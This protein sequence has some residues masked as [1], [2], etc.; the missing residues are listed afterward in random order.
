MAVL[1]LK[2]ELEKSLQAF[3]DKGESQRFVVACSG[4]YD[5][6]V[7]AHLFVNQF[8]ASKVA[9]QHFNFGLRGEESDAD[10]DYVRK[11]AGEWGTELFVEVAPAREKTGG[12]QE[13][14]R[15]LR[16]AC[17][18]K[19]AAEG[20]VV[21]TGHH[22]QDLT[23][24]VIL[25]MVRG[26]SAGKLAGMQTWDGVVFRPLLSVFPKDIR[27]YA[28][29]NRLKPREDSSNAKVEYSRNFIRHKVLPLLE[30]LAP[31]AL[32]RIADTA[33]D[34]AVVSEFFI[35]EMRNSE[36]VEAEGGFPLS[37]SV[38]E[39]PIEVVTMALGS[40]LTKWKP[41]LRRDFLRGIVRD[42]QSGRKFLARDL[43]KL[44][45]V[46]LED[47][48][49]KV[50]AKSLIPKSERFRQHKAGLMRTAEGKLWHS[51]DWK[52]RETKA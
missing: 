4:G 3:L 19:H 50:C 24:N 6:V 47:G 10:A 2:K 23:E 37:R 1:D 40:W 52:V 8:G 22:K 29:K 21:V 12:V 15:D 49:L 25:R 11:L 38:E 14:A 43:G 5:S 18:R 42:V 26:S 17:Y 33:A 51:D 39:K 44:H 9:I 20:R 36:K 34:A 45:R 28:K 32:G 48:L 41:K 30:E 46:V 7:T 27:F 13:W 16:L 31:G 35:E